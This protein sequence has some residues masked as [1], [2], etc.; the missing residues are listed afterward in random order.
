[1]KKIYAILP[2]MALIVSSCTGK[3]ATVPDEQGTG[4]VVFQ[5]SI[6]GNVA[7]SGTGDLKSAE[8]KADGKR[9]LPS[10]VI[11]G[12][13]KLK[14]VI[15]G[16]DG[17]LGTYNSM[18]GYDQP[19]MD[20]GTYNAVFTYGSPD[21]EGIAAPY[22]RGEKNF[23]VVTR[24]TSTETVSV[25]LANSLYSLCFSDWFKNYY[26]EYT[27]NISTESG[28]ETAFTGSASKPLA[29]TDPVFVKAETSLYLSG[30]A[31]KTNGVEVSFAITEIA[32]TKAGTWQTININASQVGQAGLEI[33]V[34][35]T[36]VS[37]Q[38]IPVEL[39]P[40]A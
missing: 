21:K 8:T 26:A 22:F 23:T 36:P 38:E 39:N 29:E 28:L 12:P 9:E 4:D 5:C 14:L 33:I 10:D 7:A 1:M 11:P 32:V 16:P 37:I 24:K 30:K 19:M 15:S 17:I 18:S 20:A 31:V 35:D 6:V 25:S 3:I 2:V 40:D 27:I 13:E 34:D